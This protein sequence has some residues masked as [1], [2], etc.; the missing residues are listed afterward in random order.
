MKKT[1][2]SGQSRRNRGGQGRS[3]GEDQRGQPERTM[4]VSSAEESR[5]HLAAI[6]AEA[7]SISEHP[8]STRSEPHASGAQP[9]SGRRQDPRNSVSHLLHHDAHHQ[10]APPTSQPG[11]P[12]AIGNLINAN[13][14]PLTRLTNTTRNMSIAATP[15]QAP[16]GVGPGIGGHGGQHLTASLPASHPAQAPLGPGKWSRKPKGPCNGCIEKNEH[17]DGERPCSNCVKHKR[18]SKCS[19]PA[20]AQLKN[21]RPPCSNCKVL[22]KKYSCSRELPRCS[23]CAKHNLQCIYP[24]FSQPAKNDPQPTRSGEGLIDQ[25]DIVANVRIRRIDGSEDVIYA[26]A[27]PGVNS[28]SGIT[29]DMIIGWDRLRGVWVIREQ[30]RGN[31]L[32]GTLGRNDYGEFAHT[33]DEHEGGGGM[34]V[35]MG[36][37]SAAAASGHAAGFG[38]HG[39][40][41]H[42]PSEQSHGFDVPGHGAHGQTARRP[43]EQSHGFDVPGPSAAG[44][45]HRRG[46]TESPPAQDASKRQRQS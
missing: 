9:Q 8:T 5:D 2:S 22:V 41:A 10:A 15:A 18:I 19:Y 14:E 12:M 23:R 6:G 30:N 46:S 16:W 44:S 3:R 7:L 21:S 45:M 20:A 35:S 34:G 29:Q 37:S 11:A 33:H 40:T 24:G 13:E 4:S 17:C 26:H 25:D 36:M 38:G 32:P 42:R 27:P 28:P 31:L 1:S 39:Q 43:S